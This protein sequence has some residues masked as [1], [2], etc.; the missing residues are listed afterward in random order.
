LKNLGGKSQARGLDRLG[1][2]AEVKAKAKAFIAED[3]GEI[4]YGIA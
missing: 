3:T 2:V 4:G 1:K